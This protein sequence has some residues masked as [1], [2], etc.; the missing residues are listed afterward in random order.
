MALVGIG[1][2]AGELVEEPLDVVGQILRGQVFRAG[3]L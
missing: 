3:V 1:D 2:L